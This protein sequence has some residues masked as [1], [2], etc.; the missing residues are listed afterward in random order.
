MLSAP[1]ELRSLRYQDSTRMATT[2]TAFIPE[3]ARFGFIAPEAGYL[4]ESMPVPKAELIYAI[5]AGVVAAADT[6]EDQAFSIACL[7]PDTYGYVLTE[8]SVFL[9][10]TEAGDIDD[11]GDDLT[12]TLT[13]GNWLAAQ[14]MIGGKVTPNTSTLGDRTYVIKNPSSKIITPI[15]TGGNLFTR[16]WNKT[17]DNGPMTLWCLFRFLEF[18]LRQVHHWAINTPF[19]VRG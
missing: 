16:G 1:G 4:I 8:G 9:R 5:T 7:L 10:D 19:P 14:D 3:R 12:C 18:D 11:W 15:G 17:I 6:G 13:D 2:T